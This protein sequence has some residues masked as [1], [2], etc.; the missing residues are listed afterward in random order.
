[1]F[2]SNLSCDCRWVCF[3]LLP[4]SNLQLLQTQRSP[5]PQMSAPHTS[6]SHGWSVMFS[7]L[8]PE[9]WL[10]LV[11]GLTLTSSGVGNSGILP[12]NSRLFPPMG[13]NPHDCHQIPAFKLGHFPRLLVLLFSIYI[14]AP[15]HKCMLSFIGVGDL[16]LNQNTSVGMDTGFPGLS[17]VTQSSKTVT[18]LSTCWR[19]RAQISLR[20]WGKGFIRFVCGNWAWH[21]LWNKIYKFSKLTGKFYVPKHN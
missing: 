17:A 19:W 20:A 5:A 13:R 9:L 4:F 15:K 21:H 18:K 11:S 3:S 8:L 14:F 1:M 10:L 16:G 12:P 7:A 6:F 2:F